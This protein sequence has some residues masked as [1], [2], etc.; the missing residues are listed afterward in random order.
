[1]LRS[2][3]KAQRSSL[4]QLVF[5]AVRYGAAAFLGFLADYAALWL[6]TTFC[7]AV[8]YLISAV[9][10]FVL[11]LAVNY[12]I[13]VTFVFHRTKV[14]SRAAELSGFLIISLVALG[15]NELALWCGTELL[16]FP[17]M[18]SK[19]FTGA[20]TFLWNFFARRFILYPESKQSAE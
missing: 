4:F 14:H 19:V 11:G 8:H 20:L 3:E 6:L 5:Q 9:I 1:M 2:M 10:A 12:I 15:I 16:R 13:G 17:L 18:L 7:P